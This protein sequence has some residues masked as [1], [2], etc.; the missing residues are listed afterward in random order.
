VR[1][2]EGRKVGKLPAHPA[3]RSRQ[4]TPAQ[5]SRKGRLRID[6]CVSRLHGSIVRLSQWEYIG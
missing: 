4:A 1:V 5:L 3:Y 2:L 6:R